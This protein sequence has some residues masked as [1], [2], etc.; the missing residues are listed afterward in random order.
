[1]AIEISN[2]LTITDEIIKRLEKETLRDRILIIKLFGFLE[3]G[4][5]SDID[6]ARLEHYAKKQGAYV[7]L[8]S[9]AKLQIAEQEVTFDFTDTQDMEQ[10]IVHTFE[11]KHPNPLNNYI[12]PLLKSLHVEKGEDEKSSVFEERFIAE[13]RRTLSL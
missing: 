1:M 8:K 7:F 13:A 11:E 2:A 3:K 10:Q 6:F 9:T 5:T 12:A 4:K